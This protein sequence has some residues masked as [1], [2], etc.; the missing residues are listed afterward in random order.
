MRH[1]LIWGAGAQ[2]KAELYV[3]WGLYVRG[4]GAL[5]IIITC[6]VE[7]HSANHD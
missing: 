4:G 6:E 1:S 2:Y 3:R 7:R 5:V